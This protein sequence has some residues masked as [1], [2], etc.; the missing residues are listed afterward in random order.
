MSLGLHI[1]VS[2]CSVHISQEIFANDILTALNP[3][4]RKKIAS[5]F[6]DCYDYMEA[7]LKIQCHC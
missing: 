5:M 4:F 3:S 2:D 7:R 1:V 6:C